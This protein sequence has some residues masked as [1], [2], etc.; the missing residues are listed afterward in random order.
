ME[1]PPEPSRN[2]RPFIAKRP[3]HHPRRNV[4]HKQSTGHDHHKGAARKLALLWGGGK[5]VDGD[6]DG[7]GDGDGGGPG[8]GEKSSSGGGEP[9]RGGATARAETK[10]IWRI[11]KKPLYPLLEGGQGILLGK[12]SMEVLRH[13]G[14]IWRQEACV[15]QPNHERVSPDIGEYPVLAHALVLHTACPGTV[16][17]CQDQATL[18]DGLVHTRMIHTSAIC[19]NNDTVS[20]RM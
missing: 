1:K 13:D 16:E 20:P 9:G 17:L 10:Q 19:T 11:Q 6:G 4:A 2:A 3:L 8:A 7:E 14:R 15:E 18:A 5:D 12:G